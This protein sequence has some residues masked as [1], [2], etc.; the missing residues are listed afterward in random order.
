M[1]STVDNAVDQDA[2]ALTEPTLA[3]VPPEGVDREW[4][5][6][7]AERLRGEVAAVV[8]A[9]PITMQRATPMARWLRL[10]VPL[11]HRIVA[12][13]RVHGTP[14]EVLGTFPGVEGLRMFVA[15]A[16]SQSITPLLVSRANAAVNEL[17][18]L[19]QQGGGSQRRLVALLREATLRE[20]ASVVARGESDAITTPGATHA[21]GGVDPWDAGISSAAALRAHEEARRRMH[22]AAADALGCMADTLVT[23]RVCTPALEPR[24]PHDL[25][26]YGVIGR[27]GFHRRSPAFP[28]TL[29]NRSGIDRPRPVVA[30]QGASEDS[31]WPLLAEFCSKPLPQVVLAD[32]GNMHLAIVDAP[33]EFREPIDAFAGPFVMRQAAGIEGRSVFLNAST[34]IS[35]PAAWL[36]SDVWVPRHWARDLACEVGIYREGLIGPIAKNPSQCW[37]DRV[38]AALAP[39]LLGRGLRAVAHERYDRMVELTQRLFSLANASPEDYVGF[40]VATAYPMLGMNYYTCFEVALDNTDSPDSPDNT[41]PAAPAAPAA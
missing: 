12:G 20:V 33:Y 22:E 2:Q 40:R 39:I 5:R 30:P 41:D 28:M 1:R 29:G 14:A 17:E 16:Q 34:K 4:A 3:A 24:T 25:D 26:T 6:Q 19:V 8:A 21:S 32:V 15:A 9:F 37:Y 31:R 13:V 36:V 10:Q 23:V 27:A 7:V 18:R 38:P 35:S 11:C